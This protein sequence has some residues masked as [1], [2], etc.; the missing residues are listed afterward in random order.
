MSS[1]GTPTAA[2]ADRRHWTPSRTGRFEGA[3]VIADASRASV[4]SEELADR[5]E[6]SEGW[7]RFDSPVLLLK[8]SICFSRSSPMDKPGSVAAYK[9]QQ[10]SCGP[11]PEKVIAVGKKAG[12]DAIRNGLA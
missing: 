8:F 4:A 11:R 9:A 3:V 6:G 5:S 7:T 1:C 10:K 12:S 2:S